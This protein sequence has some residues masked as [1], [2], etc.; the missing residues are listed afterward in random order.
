MIGVFVLPLNTS[1]DSLEM[2]GGKGRSLARMANAGFH[3]PGG[4]HVTTAAYRGFVADHGLQEKIPALAIPELKSGVVSFDSASQ[5]IQ[6][7]IADEDLSADLIAEIRQAYAELPERDPAVAVRSSAN[8]EDLP[9][10]SFA[11]QQ[12]TYLNVR[13]EDALIAAVRNC[14]AS[15]WTPRAIAYRHQMGIRQ[16]QVAMAVV[17]QIMVP[18]D[19]SG[20]LFTANPATGERADMIINASYGLGEAVVGG[21]VTPDTYVLDRNSLKA[22]ETVI[23]TKEQ[24]IISDGEQGTRTQATATAERHQSSLSDEATQE[25]VAL[26]VQ[27]EK[28]FDGV[29]QDIEW[30]FSKDTLWLLQSRPITNLPPQPIEVV[31]EPNPPAKILFRRQIVENMPD[32][33]CPLFEELYLTEGLEAVRG[34]KSLMIG[35]GPIFVTLHGFAYQRADWP[36]LFGKKS[37]K[38]L[39]EA[40][41]EEAERAATEKR[42]QWRESNAKMEQHDMDLFLESLSREDREA[43]DAWVASADTDR[44]AH[45]LTMPKSD[46]PTYT[47]FNKTQVNERVL[48]KWH[49]ETMPRLVATTDEWRKVDPITATDSELLQGIHTL[50]VAEGDY[51]SNDTGHTFG[52]A[53]STDD[54]LQC[55]LRETLPDHHFTSGQFLSGFK[56]R[57]MLA[58]EYIYD[59]SKLIQESDSLFELVMTTPAM[60]LMDELT[61]HAD[62]GPTLQAIDKY[63]ESYGHQGFTLDFVEAPQIEDPTPFFATLKTMVAN[64]DYSPKKHDIDATR[65][66]EQAMQDIE[67]LLDGLQYWQFRYRLWFTHRFYPIREETM[68]YLGSAWPV[69]RSFAKELGR[70]LADAGTFQLADDIYYCTTA[71]LTSAIEAH[72][73]DKAL[74]EYGR[75]AAER[76]ELREARKRLHPP[77]T[78]PPEASENPAIKFKETQILND[79]TSDTLKG[80]PVSPGTVAGPVSLI[81]SPAQF[82][83]MKSASILV[84]SM[85]NPAWTPLFA[86]ARG[87]VTDIG[88]ILGHGSIVAREYGIPAVVGTGNITQRVK[89]G[90]MLSVDGDSGLVTLLPDD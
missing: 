72:K 58:N 75:L 25:L 56:A 9:D 5:Q 4:F 33:V 13:G 23:G 37:D 85:T 12:D 20:I 62:S 8:A 39:T 87:L 14:W 19:V 31:W 30:A 45:D 49:D 3:V 77:G 21:L 81:K 68:Y 74:P 1:D 86:H 42:I 29:P 7:L 89:H 24:K 73:D 16:D 69:L 28:H 71:E 59:I 88:G 76:R 22:K 50:A 27:V 55:F 44:L 15:L 10:M 26:A 34:G 70:R 84:C 32:P 82:D 18:S 51:W 6:N 17:V 54:Q 46:N 35:G 40:E 78:V 57:T 41:L 47:A 80:I 90:E 63:L 65:K 48:K 52:V 53:K 60:R 83:Q 38:K 66:R 64:K 43:F 2:I 67:K 79:P 61:D 11:G 36:V